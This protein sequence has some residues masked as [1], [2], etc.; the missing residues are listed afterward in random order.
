MSA[1]HKR[2]RLK[3]R[4]VVIL[5]VSSSVL[6]NFFMSLGLK[7]RATALALSPT[8]Y[9]EALLDPWVIL[10]VSLLILWTLSHMTLLSWAD[11][12]YVLPITSISYAL[13]A[14]M[15]RLFLME[16]VSWQRWAG[17]AL[18]IGGIAMVRLTPISTTAGRH[19]R[20]DAQ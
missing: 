11:L 1:S 10:G 15:G 7:G 12:S 8:A 6:G 13:T 20:G 5:A 3:T 18:I 2:L 9:L 14:L 16:Q 17:I 4:L 19:W